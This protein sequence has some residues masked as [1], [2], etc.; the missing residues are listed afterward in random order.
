MGMVVNANRKSTLVMLEGTVH[1][2]TKVAVGDYEVPL[3]FKHGSTSFKSIYLTGEPG[4]TS[5]WPWAC[6]N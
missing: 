1:E 4:G 3:L 5:C 6:N 2:F